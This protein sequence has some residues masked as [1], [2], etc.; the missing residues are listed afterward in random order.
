MQKENR[1]LG[2]SLLGGINFFILGLGSLLAFGYIYLNSGSQNFQALL[3]EMGKYLPQTNLKEEMVKKAILAQMVVALIFT[4]SGWG[5]LKRKEVA[6]KATLWF[7][8]F[9]VS[10]IFIACL[11]NPAI[12]RQGFLQIVYPGTLIIYLTNKKVEEH[13]SGSKKKAKTEAQN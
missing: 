13:F 9:A 7:A 8:F 2:V 3:T 11:F 12:I 6:R 4:L 10:I 5:L 1:L